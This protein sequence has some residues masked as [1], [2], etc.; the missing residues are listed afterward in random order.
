MCQRQAGGNLP[1]SL[2]LRNAIAM[3]G[4]PRVWTRA[5]GTLSSLTRGRRLSH[6][7]RN[8]HHPPESRMSN[9]VGSPHEFFNYTSGRWAWDEE[10]QLRERYR[11]FDILELQRIA[12]ESVSAGACVSMK[13]IGEG[14]YNKSFQLTMAD[15]KVVVARIPNPNA[16]PACLT[17][18]SEVATMDFV[19]SFVLD[20][21]NSFCCQ[22]I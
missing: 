16:G 15:G 2:S 5:R 18:A 14:S 3:F 4:Y 9:I 21:A 22:S 11:K 17:T 20:H 8:Y 12:E 10:E 7:S 6:Q 19:S 13:K 1:S